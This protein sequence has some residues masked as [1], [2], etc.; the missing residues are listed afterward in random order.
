MPQASEHDQ[1]GQLPRGR[2][3]RKYARRVVAVCLATLAISIYATQLISET[4]IHVG[5]DLMQ[6]AQQAPAVLWGKDGQHQRAMERISDEFA[7]QG[8]RRFALETTG[9]KNSAS[10]GTEVAL[11]N[12]PYTDKLNR[13]PADRWRTVTSSTLTTA[14]TATLNYSGTDNFQS[15]TFKKSPQAG[16]VKLTTTAGSQ[17]I[18]LYSPK[19]RQ[20]QFNIPFDGQNASCRYHVGIPRSA[21]KS[22]CVRLPGYPAQAVQRFYLGALVPVIVS[23]TGQFSNTTWG[24]SYA[25]TLVLD[26]KT[27]VPLPWYDRLE[28]GGP[29][30]ILTI[31]GLLLLG[32]LIAVAGVGFAL[33]GVRHLVRHSRPDYQLAPF[34]LRRFGILLILPLCLWLVYLVVCYP[35]N[36]SPDSMDQWGQAHTFRMN[37]VHPA[38]HTLTEAM[39]FKVWNSPAVVALFQILIMSLVV[40]WAFEMLF[41]LRCPSFMVSLCYVCV[42]LSP[43]NGLMVITLWKDVIYSALGLLLITLLTQG[44][45]SRRSSGKL[46]WWLGL[47]QILVLLP[48][49]RHN[50][51]LILWC[52]VP[53]IPLYFHEK[54]VA[55]ALFMIVALAAYYGA[56]Q[57]VLKTLHV[58]ADSSAAAFRYEMKILPTS[59]GV[60]NLINQDVPL[61]QKD[62]DF[63]IKVRSFEDRWSYHR[64]SEV[65]LIYTPLFHMSFTI[66]HLTEY[67]KLYQNLVVSYPLLTLKHLLA[68][69][70]YLYMPWQYHNDMIFGLALGITDN[71]HNLKDASLAP[72]LRARLYKLIHR[73]ECNTRVNWFASRPAL[74]FYLVLLAMLVA[75]WRTGGYAISLIYLPV[76]INTASVIIGA[77]NQA[78]RFQYPL[79]LATSYLV[80]LG[81][82]LPI[83]QAPSA[84]SRPEAPTPS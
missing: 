67:R 82:A 56:K 8:G 74:H 17:I 26:G 18:D 55:A 30:T 34:N 28:A 47:L 9:T 14:P 50:G 40:A 23:P 31:W 5:L 63:L 11:V 71:P 1:G 25:T 84:A 27:Q 72:G 29:V 43:R 57:G 78:Q 60:A 79:V 76:F 6:S 81:F 73:I 16:I 58:P 65:N 35:G 48:L 62:L 61:S 59:Q 39:L 37:D 66:D 38:F 54:M 20:V 51:I 64:V 19:A 46:L 83:A 12:F 10:Q 24:A 22:L 53:L 52:F 41:R 15:I 32:G 42:L 49:Y 69:R 70:S 33:H 80:C 36:M 44:V 77:H 21:L 68:C 2:K 7:P 75:M 13:K 45:L 4:E 3:M